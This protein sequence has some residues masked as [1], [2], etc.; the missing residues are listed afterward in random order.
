[1]EKILMQ[2]DSDKFASSFDIVAAYD[3]GADRVISYAGIAPEDVRGLVYGTM[4]T[5]GGGDLKNTAIF[6]GGSSVL[7]GQAIL[8][9]VKATF[10]GPVRVSVMADP[11]GSN[12]TAAAA[13]LKALKAAPGAGQCAVIFAGTG[14]V[15]LR[16]ASLLAKEGCKVVLTSRQLGRAESAC[17]SIREQNNLDVVP[18]EVRD[19]AAV[20]RALEGAQI[21]LAC[22]AAGI[23][24]VKKEQWAVSPAVQVVADVNAVSPAGIGA[25]GRWE[26]ARGEAGLRGAGDRRVENENPPRRGGAP[27]RAKRPGAGPGRNLRHRQLSAVTKKDHDL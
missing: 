2:L 15:G 1:M 6:I 3:S 27:V 4:F 7:A 26:R 17:R 16:A 20:E 5:R 24:L 12:T 9:A 8:E 23:E 22:G 14:P 10:F 13:V 18:A 25:G 11:N 21:V 19:D